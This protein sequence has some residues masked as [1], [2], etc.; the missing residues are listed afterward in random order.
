MEAERLAED[1]GVLIELA[2]ET[3]DE[4]A[5]REAREGVK[6]LAEV[7][8]QM[9]LGFLLTGPF[10][11]H[12]AIVAIHA[13]AGGTEAMD[14]AEMLFRLYSHY[15]DHQGFKLELLDSLPGEEAGLKN[16]TFQVTGKNA[17]GFLR[18]EK[19]VHRLVRMSPFDAS[20]RRHT[21]FASL[22]VLPVLEDEGE[23]EV[24][25]EDL[26]ID[27][28]RSGGAG[29]QHVNKTESAV[30]ITHIP[31]G[32]VV[33][34]QNERSQHANRDTAMKIL[35]ARLLEMK[36]EEQRQQI[37]ALRGNQGE[38]AFGSQIR[39]YIFQPYQMVKDHRT[40]VESSDVGGVMDGAI[41]P[42]IRAYLEAEAERRLGKDVAPS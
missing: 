15:A 6:R 34:C 32:I 23:I 17:Y 10:D 24:D 19:G 1:I 36:E 7:V 3:G 22:D 39:S 11:S 8:E 5:E 37:G 40:G 26:R 28:Y 12:D 31:T 41:Q 14:W 30:R 18:A 38:I 9:E 25:P 13:G 29:G 42:F 33:T 27:T 4:G 2:D 20:G 35:M 21:S 16:V